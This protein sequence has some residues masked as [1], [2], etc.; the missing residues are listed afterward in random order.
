MYSS[1]YVRR[2]VHCVTTTT[3][4]L[5][6]GLPGA[7]RSDDTPHDGTR[8]LA[9]TSLSLSLARAR[10]VCRRGASQS[11]WVE[12]VVGRDA[13]RHARRAVSSPCERQQQTVGRS[14]VCCA[15]ASAA[16][17]TSHGH[18]GAISSPCERRSR[19]RGALLCALRTGVS[20]STPDRPREVVVAQPVRAHREEDGAQR[21][22]DAERAYGRDD[23]DRKDWGS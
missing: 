8:A 7:A 6:R 18:Q 19:L 17:Q 4:S 14:R 16:R 22:E 20:S 23:V 21:D 5:S 12:R 10:S 13:L 1:R 15:L 2:A 3:T 11:S 9:A